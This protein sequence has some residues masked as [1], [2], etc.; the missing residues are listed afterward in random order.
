MQ[1]LHCS[2]LPSYKRTVKRFF[3]I[4]DPSGFTVE[5]L[6]DTYPGDSVLKI[7]STF[8]R[9]EENGTSLRRE[10]V[11]GFTTFLTMSY[12]IFV[13]PAILK[14]AGMDEGAVFVA[15]C[16]AAAFGTMI[17]AL[18]ANLPI[19]MAPGMG[20]NAFFTYSIVLGLQVPWQT[21]LGAVFLSGFGFVTL[22]LTPA[23]KWIIDAIPKDIKFAMAT[24]I[25]L[26]LII[27]GLTS[28]GI[29]VDNPATLVG[30]GDLTK[31]PVLLAIICF[32]LIAAFDARKIPGAILLG[33]LAVTL[34]GNFMGV[35]KFD[36]IVS[37]PP[38]IAPTFLALNIIEAF[39]IALISVIIS[40]LFI[41]LFDSTGTLVGVAQPAGLVDEQG[42]VKNLSRALTADS[43]ATVAGAGFGT[44]STTSFVESV[45]GVNAGGRTGM[46]AFVVAI[47]F[48][49]SLFLAPL[50]G[51][52]Q[53]YATGAALVYAGSKMT[54]SLSNIDWHEP[55]TYIPSIMTAV[56]MPLTYSIATGIGFGFITYAA[57]KIL[58][59]KF[60]RSTIGITL[61]AILFLAKFAFIG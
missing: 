26:F 50:A 5:I 55:T 40:L 31:T 27:I 7:I 24:G 1:L 56:T 43:L 51:S 30:V 17:M 29:V 3:S 59:G 23:R 36:G 34:L 52:I 13:N 4:Q 39:D 19:A 57:M 47:L 41:D 6:L 42:R 9:F 61:L 38:S 45:A 25:G 15:T 16:L 12:I 18:Y 28:T 8:F 14:D 44:S 20:M 58:A 21:A 11:A 46:T 10:I 33:I 32:I 48:I 37:L 53:T 49:F 54:A 35:S 2:N 22:S 60:D